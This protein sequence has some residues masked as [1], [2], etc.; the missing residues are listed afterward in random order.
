[1]QSP[2]PRRPVR[3]FTATV[4][5]AT[6]SFVGFALI[7]ETNDRRS[8]VVLALCASLLAA[9]VAATYTLVLTPR[10]GSLFAAPTLA[11]VLFT[12][13]ALAAYASPNCPATTDPGRCTPAEAVAAA[14]PLLLLVPLLVSTAALGGMTWRMVRTTWGAW[15][16]RSR[17][18]R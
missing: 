8:L 2:A 11:L 16:R 10:Y 1:M 13:A 3:R 7:A 9:A 18:G 4:G 17:R 14:F 15:R 5:V 6:V 12:L